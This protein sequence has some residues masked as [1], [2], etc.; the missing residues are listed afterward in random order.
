MFRG[1]GITV[2][3]MWQVWPYCA[4]SA[5]SLANTT[6]IVVLWQQFYCKSQLTPYNWKWVY[7]LCSI[8]LYMC[9]T[10]S[11]KVRD[12][13][14]T[15]MNF[16]L[17]QNSHIPPLCLNSAACDLAVEAMPRHVVHSHYSLPA[18]SQPNIT[19]WWLNEM[20]RMTQPTG[21]VSSHGVQWGQQQLRAH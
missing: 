7:L 10:G 3:T 18:A 14:C 2:V 16:C 6:I 20:A 5:S 4:I 12:S 15:C 19:R 21:E 8:L 11:G 13:A 17:S 9:K 1:F